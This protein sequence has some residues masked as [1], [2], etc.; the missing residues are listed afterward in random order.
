[1]TLFDQAMAPFQH[2]EMDQMGPFVQSDAG[3]RYINVIVDR[4]SKYI[5]AWPSKSIT[6]EA[7]AKGFTQYTHQSESY[8]LTTVLVIFQSFLRHCVTTCIMG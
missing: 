7:F 8:P 6:G 5:L 3:N 4:Y 2:I 1:M